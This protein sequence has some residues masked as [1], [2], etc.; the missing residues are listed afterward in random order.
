MPTRFE[1]LETLRKAAWESIATRREF[2]WRVSLA[3]WSLL[4]AFIAGVVTH[5][6]AI[7]CG[8]RWPLAGFPFVLWIAHV[9]WLL[10]LNRAYRLDKREEGDLREAMRIEA[11][12]LENPC[13]TKWRNEIV[14]PKVRPK[15]D[16]QVDPKAKGL[17]KL[18]KHW[19]LISQ[20]FMSTALSALA[21]LS[22]FYLLPK[23]APNLALPPTCVTVP[24]NV[25]K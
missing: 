10:G 21:A 7:P 9:I 17:L 24:Q 12:Y 5:P 19:N 2:E 13:V 8:A 3:F 20:L 1:N 18:P 23:K 15:V 25:P 6:D 16:P 14:D 4:A 11:S 22:L